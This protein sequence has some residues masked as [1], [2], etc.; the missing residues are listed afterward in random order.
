MTE[1]ET[2]EGC[3]YNKYP[4]CEGTKMEDGNFMNIENLRP[5]FNCG[6]KDSDNIMDFSIKFKSELELKI[7]GLEVRI[8]ELESK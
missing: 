6:R 8:V 7:E 1:H 5:I 4:L 3:R 2:C